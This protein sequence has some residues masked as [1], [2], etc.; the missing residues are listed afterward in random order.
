[1][2]GGL[3][4]VLGDTDRSTRLRL[5]GVGSGGPS[6]TGTDESNRLF[7]VLGAAVRARIG[8]LTSIEASL[9]GLLGSDQEDYSGMLRLSIGF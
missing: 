9:D 3:L 6:Y 8:S 7:G 4:G 1:M 2:R 5:A